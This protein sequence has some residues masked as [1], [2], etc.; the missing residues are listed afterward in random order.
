[1]QTFLV[2][3]STTALA[4]IGDKTQFLVLMLAA[5]YRKPLPILFGILLATLASQTIAGE[6]GNL[7]GS[8]LTPNLQRWLTGGALLVMAAWML[9]PDSGDD[10]DKPT[11]H[12]RSVLLT[13]LVAF[14]VAEFGDKTQITT[15]VLAAHFHPLWQVILGSS[16]GLLAI[17]VPVVWLG[18]RHA[19]R[20][21]QDWT[22]RAAALL[23][24]LLGLWT[25]LR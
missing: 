6:L 8:L 15:L 4:E 3:L 22:R 20:I 17:N 23:F 19:H 24:M 12:G 11:R 10:D 13:T 16:A 21:P 14:F 18:T 25:L 1:M 7:I 9:R 2:A 5:K